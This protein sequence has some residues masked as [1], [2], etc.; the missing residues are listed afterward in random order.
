MERPNTLQLT[1]VD[2]QEDLRG[3]SRALPNVDF[4]LASRAIKPLSGRFYA[5]EFPS[6]DRI[7]SIWLS[8]G[9]SSSLSSDLCVVIAVGEGVSLSPGDVVLVRPTHGDW[10]EDAVFGGYRA[11]CRVRVYGLA[12]SF[13]GEPVRVAWDECAPVRLPIFDC[14]LPI[15]NKTMNEQRLEATGRNVLI[16]RDPVVRSEHGVILPDEAIYRTCMATVVSVGS[17]VQEVK[18]GDRVHY[19]PM[20]LLDFLFG[21]DP[22][23]AVCTELGINAVIEERL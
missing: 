21:E 19:N 13:E 6:V 2:A 16:R 18:A 4:E 14:R 1:R 17:Q 9:A 3:Q 11:E 7:G 22:D 8:D 10:I 5:V 15:D 23:L 20:G 12:C